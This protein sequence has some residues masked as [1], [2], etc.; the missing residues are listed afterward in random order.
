MYPNTPNARFDYDYYLNRHMPLVEKLMGEHLKSYSIE[1]GV[2]GGAPGQ[3][4]VYLVICRLFSESI[5]DFQAGFGPHAK[6]IRGD[7]A[8]Y[9][10]IVPTIQFSE[11]IQLP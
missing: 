11:I 8:N 10:D 4:A 2:A 5:Q 7:M 1:K 3:P 6:E 9:T